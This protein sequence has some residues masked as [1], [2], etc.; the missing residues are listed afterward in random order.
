MLSFGEFGTAI[1]YCT[2]HVIPLVPSVPQV[3]NI[4]ER[5]REIYRKKK[6]YLKPSY[7][8]L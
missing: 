8:K 4:G 2:L 3:V 5:E 6:I 1:K 7:S